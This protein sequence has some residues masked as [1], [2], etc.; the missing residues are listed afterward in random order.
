M[1]VRSFLESLNLGHKNN[2]SS[3]KVYGCYREL[4]QGT[5]FRSLNRSGRDLRFFQTA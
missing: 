5:M 2:E 1:Q 4:L 3:V